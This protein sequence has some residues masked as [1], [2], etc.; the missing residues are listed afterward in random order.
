IQTNLLSCDCKMRAFRKW[1]KNRKGRC[2]VKYDKF[3]KSPTGRTHE[4][5]LDYKITWL[6]CNSEVFK[7]ICALTGCFITLMTIVIL[8]LLKYFWR[9]IKYRHMVRRARQRNGYNIIKDNDEDMEIYDAFV[10]YHSEK[11]IWVNQVMTPELCN[12][13]L[14]F[15]LIHDDNIIPG[16]ESYFSGIMTH[17][18]RSHHIIF[19]VT[20]GWMKEGWNE[21]VRRTEA[22][23]EKQCLPKMERR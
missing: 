6:D 20:R 15:T 21:F 3:C 11:R 16:Q 14:D 13:E 4:T 23:G 9:D 19:L 17:M 18:D 2:N 8:S 1:L 12:G 10:S 7:Q 22:Y 5:L